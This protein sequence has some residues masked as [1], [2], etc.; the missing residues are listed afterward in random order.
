MKL[1]EMIPTAE[2]EPGVVA[3]FSAFADRTW[4]SRWCLPTT[5]PTLLP[6]GLALR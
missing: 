4:A 5:R 3:A 6:T 1:L 2:T